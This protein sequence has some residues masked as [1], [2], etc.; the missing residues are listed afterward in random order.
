M[1]AK[2]SVRGDKEGQHLHASRYR[3]VSYK[4]AGW[5]P[6]KKR[7]PHNGPF[8]KILFSQGVQETLHVLNSLSFPAFLTVSF[9]QTLKA[10]PTL[11]LSPPFVLLSCR[12]SPSLV[13]S[14]VS[15]TLSSICSFLPTCSLQI[16]IHITTRRWWWQVLPFLT[17]TRNVPSPHYEED[18]ADP[19]DPAP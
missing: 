19:T 2:R 5:S 14:L 13:F 15:S 1:K 8:F 12:S 3:I 10:P 6:S 7:N 17:A 9:Q 4:G 18:G 16:E 11:T